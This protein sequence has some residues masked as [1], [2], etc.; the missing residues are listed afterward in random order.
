MELARQR[1]CK[2]LGTSFPQSGPTTFVVLVNITE[3]YCAKPTWHLNFEP[4]CGDA[5]LSYLHDH[6]HDCMAST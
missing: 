6:T 1:V 5:C 2:L 3:H 4:E